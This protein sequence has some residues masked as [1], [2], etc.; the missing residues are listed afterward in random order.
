MFVGWIQAVNLKPLMYSFRLNEAFSEIIN[1]IY[2]PNSELPGFVKTASF[3]ARI[4]LIP[5]W[6]HV[7]IKHSTIL[8]TN[9]VT[10][11]ETSN[12]LVQKFE[13]EEGKNLYRER[14]PTL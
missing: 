12:K 13:L 9:S 14:L 8:L 6:K 10:I 11:T 7:L 5:K 3:T 4:C 2:Q 1:P